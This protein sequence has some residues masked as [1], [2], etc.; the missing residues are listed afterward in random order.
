MNP[1]HLEQFARDLRDSVTGYPVD[2][3]TWKNCCREWAKMARRFLEKGW[4]IRP[5]E[6]RKNV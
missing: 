2:D 1:M 4:R 3:H 5:P 6:R